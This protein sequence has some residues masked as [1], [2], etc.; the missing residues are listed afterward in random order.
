M[1]RSVDHFLRNTDLDVKSNSLP[2]DSILGP[3]LVKERR[4]GLSV[5][6]CAFIFPPLN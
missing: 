6:M 1:L 3:V 4:K 2:G 5:C